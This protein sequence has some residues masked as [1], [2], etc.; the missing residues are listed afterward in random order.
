MRALYRAANVT[1]RSSARVARV[2]WLEVTGFLFLVLGV[3]GAGATWREYH[4]Y[5]RGEAGAGKLAAG[6]LFTFLFVYFGVNSF[7]R[8]RKR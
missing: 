1:A 2:L 4:H 5:S 6:A 3:I 8:A 7:W